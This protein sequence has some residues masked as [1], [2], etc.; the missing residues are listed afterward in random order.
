M[1][2]PGLPRARQH[3]AGT[4]SRRLESSSLCP[5]LHEMNQCLGSRV[6]VAPVLSNF[7][8]C[9]FGSKIPVDFVF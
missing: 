1:V 6:R 9:F 5:E 3:G 2:P 8:D 4:L 7:L